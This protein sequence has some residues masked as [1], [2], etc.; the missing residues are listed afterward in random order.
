MPKKDWKLVL[1]KRA[2]I[3]GLPSRACNFT[4]FAVGPNEDILKLQTL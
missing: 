1:S 2:C 3:R 4:F